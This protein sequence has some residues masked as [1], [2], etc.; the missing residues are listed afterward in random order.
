MMVN[1]WLASNEKL[2]KKEMIA[3]VEKQFY[4]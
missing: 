1:S 2:K 4:T 3:A